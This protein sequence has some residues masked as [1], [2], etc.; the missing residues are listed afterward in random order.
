[1]PLTGDQYQSVM[2]VINA[3]EL[4]AERAAED[5]RRETFARLPE[6]KKLKDEVTAAG[7]T[8]TK[9]YMAGDKGAREA[10][11]KIRKTAAEMET[12][13]LAKEGLPADYLEPRYTCPDCHD[14]GVADDGTPCHCF[15]QL[16]YDIVHGNPEFRIEENDFLSRVGRTQAFLGQKEEGLENI[17]QAYNNVKD[18]KSWPALMTSLNIGRKLA[19]TLREM[20]R[21]DEALPLIRELIN[22]L[23]Y[24]SAHTEE[25][26][27]LQASMRQSRKAVDDYV[28]YLRVRCYGGLIRTFASLGVPDSARFW[29]NEM[30]KYKQADDPQIV[31]NLIPSMVKLHFDDRVMV[32]LHFDDRVIEDFGDVIQA[33]GSD[34]LDQEYVRLLEAMSDF[35]RNRNNWRASNDYL[36]RASDVRDSIE[37]ESYRSQLTDQLTIY[38]LH[39]ERTNRIEAEGR[40][41]RLF[42]IS[43]AMSL[44]LLLLAVIGVALRIA[45]TLRVLRR[46]HDDTRIELDEAKQKIEKLSK[47]YV[48]E[49]PEQLYERIMEVMETKRPYTD[50][51][52]DIPQLASMV[53]SNRTYVSKVI[54][55]QS[56]MN[57]R[58]WL[59]KYR[60]NLVQQYLKENP[61]AS[62]DELCVIAGYASKSS[63]FRH[64]KS[65]TGYTPVNW[66]ISQEEEE[67]SKGL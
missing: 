23:E 53:R 42:F 33:I 58:T 15:T 18:T 11:D 49:T 20:N 48:P 2:R 12:A 55:R 45:R 9:K 4:A 5:R 51:D 64:F 59:A 63:L 34:T 25:F 61:E 67:E 36:R 41:R 19:N 7:V 14:T 29:L 28:D 8:A 16:A 30:E 31:L 50:Q 57:F 60:I 43:G 46:V 37:Q 65:I 62:L 47:G 40:N 21:A 27:E 54:N 24:F 35:E 32:K 26:S 39:D 17:K 22:K 6:L 66:L 38:Q 3:R 1:M 56:G 52:F 10:F 13:L 44:F